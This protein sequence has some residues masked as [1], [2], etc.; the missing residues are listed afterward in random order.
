MVSKHSFTHPHSLCLHVLPFLQLP[1]KKPF[2]HL[3]SGLLGPQAPFPLIFSNALLLHLSPSLEQSISL[4]CSS[5]SSTIKY[6]VI[7]SALKSIFSRPNI[8][9]SY[10]FISLL[11]FVTKILIKLSIFSMSTYFH[12]IF[13]L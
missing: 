10:H 6:F 1:W 5:F 8:P 12:L 9:S 2:F 13:L 4:D 11:F 7:F 3:G